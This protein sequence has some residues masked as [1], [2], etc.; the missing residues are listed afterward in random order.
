MQESFE[1]S[2]IVFTWEIGSIAPILGNANQIQQVL[3]NLFINAKNAMPEGGKLFL[4]AESTE[5]KIKI[6]VVDTGKGI[7][8]EN[9]DK[10]F[11]PFFTTNPSGK[12][13]GLGLSISKKII[14]E[15]GGEVQVKSQVGV[16]TTFT[17]CLP[18]AK[19]EARVS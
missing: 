2:K 14:K 7:P 4:K 11:E 6:H 9:L 13:T 10:I 17:L 1:K 8:P 15:H 5:Q 18:R 3:M 19:Q 12:G 16:G